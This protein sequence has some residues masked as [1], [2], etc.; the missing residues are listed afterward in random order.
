MNQRGNGQMDDFFG[1]PQKHSRV[2]SIIASEYFHRW[3]GI[4]SSTCNSLTYVDF[5]AGPGR[6]DNGEPST[7]ILILDKLKT[8]KSIHDR[9]ILRFFEKDQ[10]YAA[11]LVDE[12]HAHEV[13]GLLKHR[14]IVCNESVDAR[15]PD[16]LELGDCTFTFIDPYGYNDLSLGLLANVISTFGSDTL[17]LLSTLSIKR[18]IHDARQVDN[19]E[20]ILGEGNVEV[21]RQLQQ[22]RL[23]TD[24]SVDD[25]IVKMVTG[26]IQNLYQKQ[27]KNLFIQDFSMY[28]SLSDLRLYSLV[29]ITKHP[30]GFQQIKEVFEKNG[31]CDSNGF[32][33]Y[34]YHDKA[35]QYELPI[36]GILERSIEDML[37]RFSGM[38]VSVGEI[39]TMYH[40]LGSR[41]TL[42]SIQSMLE[43]LDGKGVIEVEIQTGKHYKETKSKFAKSVVVKFPDQG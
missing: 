40:S 29:H 18:N 3:A 7:P 43:N 34:K 41:H 11:R 8:L 25:D 33:Q 6:F 5:F 21:L 35:S 15:I 38:H 10:K 28:R 16:S 30:K 9:A 4:M 37:T 24:P 39:E 27:G 20:R 19:L 42:K 23:E 13:T 26:Q 14:P 36:S 32:P 31:S 1:S 12:I 2:K 17:F 22:S